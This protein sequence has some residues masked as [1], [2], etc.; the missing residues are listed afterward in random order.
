MPAVAEVE[1]PLPPLTYQALADLAGVKVGS[2]SKSWVNKN[3]CVEW[4]EAL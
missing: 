3:L 4:A 1:E 2:L